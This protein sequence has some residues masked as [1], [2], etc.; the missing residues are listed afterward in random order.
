MNNGM[1]L[2]KEVSQLGETGTRWSIIYDLTNKRISL[3]MG[4]KYTTIYSFSIP[5]EE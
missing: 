2:L 5:K 4:R 1:V 3:V